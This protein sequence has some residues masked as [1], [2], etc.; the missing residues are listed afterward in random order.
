MSPRPT[1][2]GDTARCEGLTK[3]NAPALMCQLTKAIGYEAAVGRIVT[4][5]TASRST[6][7]PITPNDSQFADYK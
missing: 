1:I 2:L 5:S 6:G 3:D 7:E 4:L